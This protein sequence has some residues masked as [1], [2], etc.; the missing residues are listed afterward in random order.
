HPVFFAFCYS[1]W[2]LLSALALWD[3]KSRHP[4]LWGLAWLLAN[5]A[6]FNAGY[7]EV[8]VALIGGLNLTALGFFAVAHRRHPRALATIGRMTAVSI[9]F[10]ALT[11]P[12]WVSFLT[13][14]PAAYTAHQEIRATQ[15]PWSAVAGLFDDVFYLSSAPLGFSA[16]VAPGTSLLILA[17]TVL[18]LMRWRELKDDLFFRTNLAAI[19]LWGS[20]VFG[21][22]PAAVLKAIP[23]F[24]R[25]GHIYV[26]FSYLLVIHLTI[27]SAYGFRCLARE[28]NLRRALCDAVGIALVLAFLTALYGFN[29]S[30]R[31]FSWVYLGCAGGAALGLPLVY[32]SLKNR[33]GSVPG[34]LALGVLAFVPNYRFGL[35]ASGDDNRLMIA[36]PRVVLDAPSPAIQRIKT[37]PG[38]FRATALQRNLDGDYFAVYGLEDIRSCAPLS[39]SNLV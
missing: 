35:Y 38:P 15:L 37:E 14:L 32:V 7:V 30:Y 27:Q 2:I 16:A 4:T 20:C 19:V 33:Y 34:W 17:G 29:C 24:N 3:P 12:T 1:P 39:N 5:F 13:E 26:D 21:L 22:M 25:V 31:K 6:C 10:V 18:S 28:K 23:F 8:A 36:G 9:L 11:A